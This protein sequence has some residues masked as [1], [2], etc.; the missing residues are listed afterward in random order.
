MREQD[1]QCIL[2]DWERSVIN[3]EQPLSENPEFRDFNASVESVG[4]VLALC[5]STRS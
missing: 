2:K 4:A 3:V 5:A 1:G